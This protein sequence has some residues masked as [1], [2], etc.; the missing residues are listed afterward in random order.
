[1]QGTIIV[2]DDNKGVL[3]AV[4][5]LLKN[6][7]ERII[8][9]T[10]PITLPAVLR[11]ENAQV[12][13]L[14]MNFS[15]GL[16]TGNEG[17]Y[18]LHEI[19]KM[20]PSLPVVLF[21]AYADIDLAVRGIKEGAADFIV[22]PWDNTRL[23]DTLSATCRNS[24]KGKKKAELRRVVSSMYWGESNAMKQLRTLIEKVAQTDANILIT[25][26]NGTG[27]E[28][29]ARE[30]HALSERCRRNMVT[31]D[32]GAVLFIFIV[33]GVL[34]GLQFSRIPV[35]QVFR[36]YTEGKKSW[37]RPLLFIQFTGTAF[38]FALL[39]LVLVQSNHMTN[40]D[41][42]FTTERM[43]F[44]YYYFSNPE[45]ARSTFQNLPYV[46]AVASSSLPLYEGMSGCQV[47]TESG[48]QYS[49][50][51]NAIDK[52]YLPFV[53]IKLKEG[54]NLKQQDEV[55]VNRKF[56]EVMHWK[57]NPIGRQVRNNDEILGTIVGVTEDFRSSNPIFVP[58]E[59][60][61]FQYR[62][63]FSGCIQVKLKEPFDENLKKLNEDVKN[64]WPDGDLNFVS[65]T[66]AT[67]L[68]ISTVVDF[69]SVALMA[70]ITILFVTLMG[71]IGY[72][73]DEMQRRSKEIAIRKVN[74]AEASSILL[75]LSKDIFW[76][77]MPAVCIGTLGAWYLGAL[78]TDQFSETAE[79]PIYYYILI[80]FVSLLFIIGCVVIK[81]WRIANDNPVNSIKSE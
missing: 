26:E 21:T 61:V 47:T 37:K 6:S 15:S 78:W 23:V 71:L 48:N 19:K 74:G 64:I 57:E 43:A 28:M 52:D 69:R 67:E 14:D 54:R 65:E 81:T 1:M 51:G 31:V 49:M 11:E 68:Q 17:L 29:L 62:S 45:N 75:L 56:L 66:R 55:V 5:L 40:I 58:E 46:E 32:M 34:P 76:T 8:T 2:V 4:K 53:G 35:T 10:S 59:P 38:I 63:D 50:R 79:F 24:S 44:T 18:W 39:A 36:R 42:G 27:K 41:R 73:N 33:G 30:I 60:V 16:N 9:L 3:S 22:K 7:F 77:S 20:Q 80:A 70:T 12:V 72:I 13:L 25:G